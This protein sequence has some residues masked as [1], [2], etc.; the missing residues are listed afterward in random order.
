M[1]TSSSFAD[2]SNESTDPEMLF[3][4]NKTQC[5]GVS[6]GVD[7]CGCGVG[8]GGCECVWVRVWMGEWVRTEWV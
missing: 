4:T 8:V 2:I 3:T 5:V 6:V 1:D 7:G